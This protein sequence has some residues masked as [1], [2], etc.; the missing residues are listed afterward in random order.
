LDRQTVCVTHG[1]VMRCLFRF[2]EGMSKKD[3]A[4]LDIQQDRLL[5]LEGRSLEWL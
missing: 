1:G 3:A 4:R 2:V 5:R